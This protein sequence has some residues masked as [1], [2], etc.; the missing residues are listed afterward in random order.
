MKRLNHLFRALAIVIAITGTL[1]S[2][3]LYDVWCVNP[4]TVDI[5]IALDFSNGLRYEAFLQETVPAGDSM[6]IAENMLEPNFTYYAWLANEHSTDYQYQGP[7]AEEFRATPARSQHFTRIG[8]G[9]QGINSREWRYWIPQ[10]VDPNTTVHFIHFPERMSTCTG[11]CFYGTG[12]DH[13]YMETMNTSWK[14]SI[15]NGSGRMQSEDTLWVGAWD[16]GHM[17][18]Y[19]EISSP[20]YLEKGEYVHDQRNGLF[21]FNMPNGDRYEYNYEMG[22]QHGLQVMFAGPKRQRFFVYYDHG[23]PDHTKPHKLIVR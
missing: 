6:L 9:G 4:Y 16:R 19:F 11:R 20:D 22:V 23:V 14:D 17:H 5:H 15:P 10:R 1:R 12:I 13:N 3:A 2:A 8:P 21:V 7:D 18:G